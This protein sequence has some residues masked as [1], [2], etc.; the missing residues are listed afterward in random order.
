M[1][2]AYNSSGLLCLWQDPNPEPVFTWT[3]SIF[4]DYFGEG[5]TP[6]MYKF[7]AEYVR[8]NFDEVNGEYHPGQLEEDAFVRYYELPINYRIRLHDEAM[9]E[10]ENLLNEEE[11]WRS[12]HEIGAEHDIGRPLYYSQYDEI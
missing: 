10:L 6:S 2:P 3:Y 1:I 5:V 12:G 7:L 4:E 11:T 8:T 9:R